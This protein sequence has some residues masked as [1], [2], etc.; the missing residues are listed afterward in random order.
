MAADL[1][2]PKQDDMY[3][4]QSI[5]LRSAIQRMTLLKGSLMNRLRD[6]ITVDGRKRAKMMK[7]TSA[8]AMEWKMMI[9]N[10]KEEKIIEMSWDCV[11]LN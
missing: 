1:L 10:K 5:F 6:V 2:N 7:T 9:R 3:G 11:C 4:Y 8:I